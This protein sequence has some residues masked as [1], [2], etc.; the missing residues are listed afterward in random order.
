MQN[1]MAADIGSTLRNCSDTSVTGL[2]TLMFLPKV[3]VAGPDA[4][5]EVQTPPREIRVY[6]KLGFLKP[7]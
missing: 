1:V 2:D 4:R 7:I 5:D 6:V 3:L